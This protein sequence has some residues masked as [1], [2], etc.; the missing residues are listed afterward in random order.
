MCC[1]SWCSAAISPL[2]PPTPGCS[3]QDALLDAAIEGDVLDFDHFAR[4]VAAP[5]D[6]SLEDL[7]FYDA[8]APE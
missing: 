7:D 6:E 4:L 2:P 3:L 1:W 5:G 8:R